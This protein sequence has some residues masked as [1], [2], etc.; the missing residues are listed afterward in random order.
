[1]SDDDEFQLHRRMS[2]G[3][4]GGDDDEARSDDIGLEDAA[5]DEEEEQDPEAEDDGA[6]P[7]PDATAAAAQAAPPPAEPVPP[8]G[9]DLREIGD[10]AVWSVTSAKS[11]N[12]V[13]LLRDGQCDTFW[14]LRFFPPRPRR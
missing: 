6:S 8:P 13:E 5:D 9:P 4:Y 1:M 2:P 14:Q 3:S 11:G 12:G 7:P 10:L